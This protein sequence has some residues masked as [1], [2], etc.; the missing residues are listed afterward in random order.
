MEN[1][2]HESENVKSN[3]LCQIEQSEIYTTY[4]IEFKRFQLNWLAAKLDQITFSHQMQ[5][6]TSWCV[7]VCFFL[8]LRA[9]FRFGLVG[10]SPFFF[11]VC[12]LQKDKMLSF[13]FDRE[14]CIVQHERKP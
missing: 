9:C 8:S 2:L 5:M 3:L 11:T 1:E 13:W 7:S 4:W 6:S 12:V 14:K 10:F